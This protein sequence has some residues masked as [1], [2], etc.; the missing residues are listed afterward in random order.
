MEAPWCLL[1]VTSKG[2]HFCEPIWRHRA[3]PARVSG[4]QDWLK[5]QS[6]AASMKSQIMWTFW[7][8]EAKI[9][10]VYGIFINK[11]QR[12]SLICP[13]RQTLACLWHICRNLRNW[14]NTYFIWTRY[15]FRILHLRIN[16]QTDGY[17]GSVFL[18]LYTWE[19]WEILTWLRFPRLSGA[20]SEYD[21]RYECWFIS[22]CVCMCV[23]VRTICICGYNKCSILRDGTHA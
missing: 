20:Q 22:P 8:L 11:D 14:F 10:Y 6:M 18:I 23:S 12:R 1:C 13:L 4:I 16:Y 15:T 21:D 19:P 7:N 5:N 2:L 9:F 3:A 17:R